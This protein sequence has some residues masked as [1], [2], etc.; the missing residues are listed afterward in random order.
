MDDQTIER[1]KNPA[2][3]KWTHQADNRARLIAAGHAL[4]TEKGVEGTTVKE[5]ARVADVSPGLFHYYFESKDELLLA[6]LYEA[7]LRF[8]DQLVKDLQEAMVSQDFPAVAL[9]TALAVGHKDPAWYRLRYELFA[10]GLRRPQ[11]LPAVAKYMETARAQMTKTISTLMGM[12]E[13]KA[14]SAAIVMLAC[15]DGLALQQIIQPDL[16][17]EEAYRMVRRLLEV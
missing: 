6:V 9:V 2:K 14:K 1:E 17:M 8:R 5:I 7:G 4:M 3:R 12:D 16:E 10:L 13:E 15:V 11:M